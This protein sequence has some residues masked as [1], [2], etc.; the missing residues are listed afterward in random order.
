MCF[1]LLYK[2]IG[3]TAGSTSIVENT[4]GGDGVV[5][6]MSLRVRLTVVVLLRI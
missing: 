4:A 1:Y 2:V 6:G 3:D 5:V